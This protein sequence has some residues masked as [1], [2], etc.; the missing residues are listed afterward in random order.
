MAFD[1]VLK[2]CSIDCG[3]SRYEHRIML[4]ADL[5]VMAMAVFDW[6]VGQKASDERNVSKPLVEGLSSMEQLVASSLT[7]STEEGE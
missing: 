7:Q 5:L 3:V 2:D 6:E 4:S 1:V